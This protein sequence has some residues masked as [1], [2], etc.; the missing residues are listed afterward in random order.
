MQKVATVEVITDSQGFAPY[1]IFL[2]FIK[3]QSPGI[4]LFNLFYGI[5]PDLQPSGSIF[6]LPELT[7]TI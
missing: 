1:F 7:F 5:I 4:F 3:C 6:R 2:L